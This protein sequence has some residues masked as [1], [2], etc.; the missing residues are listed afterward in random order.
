V[1]PLVSYYLD[2]RILIS[3]DRH[4]RC[5]DLAE[6]IVSRLLARYGPNLIIIHGAAPGVDE[7]FAAACREMGVA[8]E[9]HVADCKGLGNVAGPARNRQMVE[10]RC[11]SGRRQEFP[12]FWRTPARLFRLSSPKAPRV[13]SATWRHSGS[14]AL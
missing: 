3:G 10:V 4:W 7:S 5:N 13:I 2:M 9:P 8:A 14:A 12:I 6:Q 11:W 1:R